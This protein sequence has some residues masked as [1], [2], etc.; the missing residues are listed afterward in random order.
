V[1][2]YLAWETTVFGRSE[3][4]VNNS[5]G[6]PFLLVSGELRQLGDSLIGVAELKCELLRLHAPEFDRASLIAGERPLAIALVRR[7]VPL[8]PMDTDY[9]R[10]RQSP[11]SDLYHLP[12]GACLAI[13]EHNQRTDISIALDSAK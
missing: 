6:F 7:S 3:G 11:A 1:W 4:Q 12:P 9:C 8:L 5:F 2:R 13:V 10:N